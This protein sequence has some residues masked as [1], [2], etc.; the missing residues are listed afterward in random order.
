[1]LKLQDWTQTDGVARVDI[2]GLDN[3]DQ[4]QTNTRMTMVIGVRQTGQPLMSS[5]AMSTLAWYIFLLLALL[6]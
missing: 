3:S 5:P 4:C 2:A 1:M 6:L